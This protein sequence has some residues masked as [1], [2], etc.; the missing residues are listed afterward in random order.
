MRFL[1]FVFVLMF[2]SIVFGGIVVNGDGSVTYTKTLTAEEWKALEWLVPDGEV[3][4]ENA[5]DHKILRSE[6]RMVLKLSDKRPDKISKNEKKNLIKNST[7]KS[8][9]ERDSE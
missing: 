7:L 8:R 1:S 4:I 9:K 6:D 3:W 2:S 5:I